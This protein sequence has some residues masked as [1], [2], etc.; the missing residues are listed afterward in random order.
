MKTNRETNGWEKVDAGKPSNRNHSHRKAN[1]S[2]ADNEASTGKPDAG[3]LAC[4]VW[5]G[6][7]AVRPYLS[8][9]TQQS[10]QPGIWRSSPDNIEVDLMVP[11]ALGGSGRRAAQLPGHD[12]M[13]ARKAK[14]LEAVLVDRQQ[15]SVSALD[16][17]DPRTIQVFVAGPAALLVAKLHKIWERRDTANRQD[18]KDAHDIYRLLVMI[19]T[20]QLAARLKVLLGENLSADVTREALTYLDGLFGEEDGLGV[21]MAARHEGILG[22]FDTTVQSCTALAQ[23]LL[24]AMGRRV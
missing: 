24:K 23:D 19:P 6:G 14:G 10:G 7:K 2:R 5:K 3:K 12:H 11:D 9:F 22:D 15:M 16:P 21:Q 17:A 13:A 18:D 20:Q 1:Q 8:L 4:P